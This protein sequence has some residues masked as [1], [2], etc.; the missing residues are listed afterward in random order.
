MRAL[1]ELSTLGV[2]NAEEEVTGK[3]TIGRGMGTV[4]DG[5]KVT[6]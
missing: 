2:Y 4:K 3:H 1:S 5:Q 6:A